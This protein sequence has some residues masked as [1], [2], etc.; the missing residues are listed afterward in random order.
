MVSS[1]DFSDVISHL[2]IVLPCTSRDRGWDNHVLL[3]G[4]TGLDRPTYA[5]TEQPRTVSIERIVEVAGRVD[6]VCLRELC[7]WIDVWIEAA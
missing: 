1:F 2:A 4:D 5:V 6:D 3:T 7:Q